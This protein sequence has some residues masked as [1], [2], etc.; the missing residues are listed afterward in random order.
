M[1]GA[2]EGIRV[3]DLGRGVAA[4]YAAMLLAEQG[5]DVLRIEPP[6]RD[7]LFGAPSYHVFN[8]SK[9]LILLDPDSE[10]GRRRVRN[11]ADGADVVVVDLPE[12]MARARGLAWDVLAQDRTDLV[13]LAMPPFGSRGPLA[14]EDAGESLVAAY[15]GLSGGQWSGSDQ[16]VELVLPLAAYGAA[17]LGAGAAT[18]ALYERARSGAGQRVE[19]SW[20][21]GSLAMQTGSLLRG[22]G[23]ERLAGTAMDPLGPIP[24]YRLFRAADGEYL[25]IAAGTPR[26]FHRL[27]LLLDHPEWISDPRW[28]AAPWGIV[29]PDHRRALVE[30]IAPI[31]ATKPRAEWL[32]LLTEA[33]IPNAPVSFREQFIDDPQVAAL[34]LRAEIE[35]SEAART[36]QIGT[37]LL[38]HGTPGPP[39]RGLM[40][41]AADLSRTAGHSIGDKRAATPAGVVGPL[42]GLRVLDFSGFIAGSYCPMTLADFGADVIKVESPEGDA[43]RSFGFGFLGWNRGKRGLSVDTRRPE[44]QAVVH[45]LVRTADVIVENFRPGSAKRLGLDYE[46]LSAINPRLIYST[47][48]AFGDTGPL[49]GAPG[50]DPL[51][52]ARAGAMAAQGGM[53]AGH[54]PV[55]FTAAICDYAAAL[56]SVYGICAALVARERTGVGQR[57]ESSLVHSALA[58]QAGEFIWYEGMPSVPAGGPARI[59]R[60][61]A[62]RF[63]RC[64]DDAWLKLDVQNAVQWAAL[65]A[66][67]GDAALAA[68]AVEEALRAD[69]RGIVA[70]M[71]EARFASE[72]V[73]YWLPALREVGV[74]VA[75]VVRP[76]DLFTDPQVVAN[77]LIAEHRH[78][79]WGM[80]R[81]SGVLAKFART[82]GVARCAAPLLGQHSRE[83]LR[84]L[85][86]DDVR[87]DALLSAGVIVETQG[88]A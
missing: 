28:S 41:D 88:Q 49:A 30:S 25:F 52:Q 1:A 84:E 60:S 9:R 36:V 8:R 33:D 26:F 77:D 48:T 18:A 68:V 85:G 10:D 54:P 43:F 42:V 58:A 57:V 83:V 59:G 53:S 82:P 55:Y 2:L 19:V 7:R 20:L 74:P 69:P 72:S 75:P 13:Y 5:A 47:V 12:S 86:Y 51:L 66:T 76:P 80:V 71:L 87:I 17:L 29:D 63:F 24:V 65:V 46:T 45:D 37:P 79:G 62:D 11:L 21:A 31:I 67:L 44:G 32:Q 35:D 70:E 38:L 34:G 3:L 50:F 23:V 14:E 39:P 73:A 27:C 6:G 4:P 15:S 40:I 64:A 16:P 61:A 56:L 22:E 81:Q 78:A